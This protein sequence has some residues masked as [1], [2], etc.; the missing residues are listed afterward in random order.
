[1][2][3]ELDFL[4]GNNT[5]NFLKIRTSY[6]ITGNADIDKNARFPLYE[7]S[8]ISYNGQD[9]IFPTQLGN[10]NLQWETSNVFDIA[11]EAGLWKDRVTMELAYYNKRSTDVLLQ[12]QVSPSTGFSNFWDN[13]AEI[14]NRGWELSIKTNNIVRK[15][16]QWTSD[17]NFAR[18]YNE[19][20]SIGNYTPDAVSGGTNDTRVI[21]GRPI[22]SFMLVPF[23][24]IDS[25][26]GRPVFLDLDG[27]ETFDYDFKNGR[28]YVGDGLPDVIM[29]INNTIRFKNW[30]ISTLINVSIGAQIFDSSGKRQMGL[31][32]DWN[33]RTDIL[34]RWTQPGDDALYPVLTFDEANYGFD[35]GDNAPWFN[36]SLYVYDADYAR[37]KRLVVGYTFPNFKIRNKNITG[38]RVA[39]TATNLLTITNFPGL[40]P[41]IVRDF[42]NPQDRNLSGNITYLTPPQ[43]R[44]YSVQLNFSF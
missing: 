1:V 4:K 31:M 22:G 5:L 33:M 36:T 43:E 21:V 30:D 35:P 7:D 37:L 15:N 8:N 10:E 32:T 25:E 23:S 38:I 20:V 34:D 39:F 26:S 24:H 14:M 27:N 9:I 3:S 16:F 41:E 44:A 40:D 28:S 19:I 17:M 18:N 6:G 2:L 12:V 13:A 42:E 29:G 11:L